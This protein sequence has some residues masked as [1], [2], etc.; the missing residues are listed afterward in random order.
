[1][2]VSLT[3]A[4]ENMLN[5]A[6]ATELIS[7]AMERAGIA[8]ASVAVGTE[9]VPVAIESASIAMASCVE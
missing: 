4:Q 9:L 5:I 7:V 8:M 3:I 2:R 6:I 1:M